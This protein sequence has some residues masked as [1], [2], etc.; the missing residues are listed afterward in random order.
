MEAI[1]AAGQSQHHGIF[2]SGSHEITIIAAFAVS[3][4]TP[5]H[6]EKVLNSSRFYT[7]DY[8]IV[9]SSPLPGRQAKLKMRPRSSFEKLMEK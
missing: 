3:T 7:F 8:F 5:C 9:N 4:V 1:F 2:W 6:Q